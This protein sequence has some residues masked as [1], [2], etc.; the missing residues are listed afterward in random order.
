MASPRKK[1]QTR[2]MSDFMA[3]GFHGM[4]NLDRVQAKIIDENRILTPRIVL[5]ADPTDTGVIL[6][7]RGYVPANTLSGAHSLW[8]GSVL[9]C[10]TD[11]MLYRIEGAT[12]IPLYPISFPRARIN[13]LEIDGFVYMGNPFWTAIYDLTN[14]VI[15]SWGLSLPDAPQVVLGE[16]NLPPGVYSLCYTTVDGNRMGGSGRFTRVRWEQESRGITLANMPDDAVCWITQANGDK[17][18]LALM[19]GNEVVGPT[20]SPLPTH[21]VTGPPAMAHCV[22]AHGRVWAACGK[23]VYYSFPFQPEWFHP[24]WYLPFPE[25][26]V[27]IAPTNEGLFVNSKTS[28]W[29]LDGHEPGKMK[30]SLVG[31]GAIPGTLTTAQIEGGGYEISR[32]LSQIPTPVWANRSGIVTGTNTGHL[33]RVTDGRLKIALRSEGAATYWHRDGFPQIVMALTGEVQNVNQEILRINTEG[34]LFE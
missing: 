26:I 13:Y 32:K 5:N 18:F 24:G 17:P 8:G 31:E 30:K 4:A 33:V 21:G 7:R 1:E 12:A 6:K 3:F 20:A 28:T 25:D 16:G 2:G 10:A 15:M 14:D 9:L 22:Q 23:K 29:Y 19:S 11:T 34:Q 27:L